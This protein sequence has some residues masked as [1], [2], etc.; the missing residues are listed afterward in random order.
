[1]AIMFRQEE[2]MRGNNTNNYCEAAMRILKDRILDRVRCYN[3]F[4][5]IDLIN[6]ELDQYYKKIL[7]DA[8]NGR[9]DFRNKNRSLLTK[10]EKI[11]KE[12]I[13]HKGT[14]IYS[15]KSQ[16]KEGLAYLVDMEIDDW[17][18]WKLL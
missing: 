1:M 12:D 7:I 9:L 14:S 16:T 18:Q 8:G 10:G 2:M 6:T 4:Q 3:V 11:P 13:T 15:V 5:L 17:S